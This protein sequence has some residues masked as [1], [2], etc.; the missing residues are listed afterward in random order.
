MNQLKVGGIIVNVVR[1]DINNL[2]LAVYPPA[3]RV[4]IA[5]PLL[6]SDESVRLFVI[7]KLAWIKKQKA[8]FAG[9][10]RQTKREY[11]SGE[12]QPERKKLNAPLSCTKSCGK[13]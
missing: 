3:G 2:H 5:T 4:R 6:V 1:K 13:R 11:V 7:S 10:E 12:S 9:Q 8:K